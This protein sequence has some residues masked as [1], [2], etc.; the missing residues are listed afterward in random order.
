MVLQPYLKGQA[1]R[2]KHVCVPS[3]FRPV[4]VQPNVSAGIIAHTL[5]DAQ[6]MFRR[7][8]FAYD[9]LPEALKALV[10]ADNDTS[11][12]LKFSNGSSLRVG[13]SLR[14]STFQYLHI[15]E[16]GKICAK[17]PDKAR[18]IITG[19][20]NTVTAGQYIF[21]ES[22][23]EG[24][25]G[26]FYE[27]CKQSQALKHADKGLTQLDFK[28][29]FFPWWRHDSYK[30]KESVN[31]PSDLE[32]YFK[33]LYENS[34]I[35]LSASQCA[36]YCKKALTQ[37]EDMKREYPSTPEESF[38][39]SNEGLYYGKQI[40]KAR[41]EK[42]IGR[43]PYDENLPVYAALDI[44]FN[45]STAV[46]WYQVYGPEV[47]LIDY[48]ESSGEALTHYIK[49]FKEKPYIVEKYFVPHDANSHEFST[50]LTRVQV[51]R[52]LGIEFTTV[53]KLSIQEGI[54]AVRS[55]LNRC[56]FDEVKC[57]KGIKSLECYRKEWDDSH[58]CWRNSPRHDF[59]SHGCF[60]SDTLID[61]IDG[62]KKICDI[63][64]GD[65]VCT[66]NGHKKVTQ[67]YVYDANELL[68]ITTTSTKFTCTPNHKIFTGDGL[69]YA[70]A[71]RYNIMLY[72]KKGSSKLCRKVYGFRG[73]VNYLGFRDSFLLMNQK[74]LSILTAID[75]F[76]MDIIEKVRGERLHFQRFKE[77]CGRI[78]M[79]KFQSIITFIMSTGIERTMKLKTC[80]VYT[81]QTIQYW[82]QKKVNGLE[83]REIKHSFEKIT[84]KQNYGMQA[85]KVLNGTLNMEKNVGLEEKQEKKHAKSVINYFKRLFRVALKYVLI[86]VRQKKDI[87]QKLI[88]KKENVK[89]AIRNLNVIN[90]EQKEHVIKI[91]P[92]Y[93]QIT[94]KVYDFEVEDDHCYYANGI[95]VSNSD[96][97][98][99]LSVS[100]IRAK[101]REDEE[102]EYKR[103]L[104]A[105]HEPQHSPLYSP[106]DGG[107]F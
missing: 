45:D 91:V 39:T 107:F 47:R 10:T 59:S 56:W 86:N 17:Y 72:D 67:T 2:D 65:M 101:T 21:I 28:F 99:Y 19:A 11:Q 69:L 53:S 61:G 103:H 13:T 74:K 77:L 85:K 44:G 34:K 96:A 26:Y 76:G 9:S 73:K 36:W 78:I 51:A 87:Y 105:L 46:W 35:N 25:E 68:E 84:K 3:L 16:F 12:M 102:K 20:L 83:A 27:M 40:V 81:D 52:G 33:E 97:F 57:E 42:R 82:K 5:E 7:V 71:L 95:L 64:V 66:P 14:S 24:R 98:R 31:I 94:Q 15:S 29:F 8:K 93:S 23:A 58:G 43:V 30:L 90:I 60:T 89:Y 4:L 75:M 22:T 63:Q 38:L 41:S 106:W 55:L 1:T 6:Q 49:V 104:Q 62:S 48:Y 32:T 80:N 100:L 92:F 88:Q 37:G 50:G 79:E 70:D 18:E 54:D